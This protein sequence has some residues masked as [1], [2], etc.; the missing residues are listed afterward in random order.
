[1]INDFPSTSIENSNGLFHCPFSTARVRPPR[2][3]LLP[4]VHASGRALFYPRHRDLPLRTG[5]EASRWPAACLL[6]PALA[7]R[8]SGWGRAPGGIG[9]TGGMRGGA[10]G[11]H[12][13]CHY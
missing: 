11:G 6:H 7:S 2:A 5:H 9:N 3:T 13:T 10:G 4:L 1:F 12:V 8:A